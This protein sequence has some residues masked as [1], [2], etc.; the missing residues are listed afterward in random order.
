MGFPGGAS[1]EEPACQCRR[2]KRR[3]LEP[4]VGEDPLEESR[5]TH[6]SI[7]TWRTSWTEGPGGPQSTGSRRV[8]HEWRALAQ[9]TVMSLKAN[10]STVL[11]ICP[12]RDPGSTSRNPPWRRL[13]CTGCLS[14]TVGFSGQNSHSR[15]FWREKKADFGLDL[16]PRTQSPTGQ[17][18]PRV[19]DK[20]AC[21]LQQSERV[22]ASSSEE[23]THEALGN[24]HQ[25][26]PCTRGHPLSIALASADLRPSERCPEVRNS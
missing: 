19:T 8:G 22:T 3:W 16:W 17:T 15:K 5:A 11:L 10:S 26:V 25:S 23:H 13:S 4:W 6:S 12:S 7:L 24:G 9:H 20:N 21:S 2:H 1:G 14:G 18:P